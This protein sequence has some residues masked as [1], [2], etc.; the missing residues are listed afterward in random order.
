MQAAVDMIRGDFS[1]AL[2]IQR[3]AP[4][5]T[6]EIKV[7]LDKVILQWAWFQ[8]VLQQEKTDDYQLIVVDA[9]EEILKLMENITELYSSLGL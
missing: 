5:N 8:N 3:T 6:A 4:A 2:E 7:E 1:R 9:S